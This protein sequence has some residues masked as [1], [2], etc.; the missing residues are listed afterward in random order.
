MPNKAMAYA[1][2]YRY[3][4]TATHRPLTPQWY[5]DVYVPGLGTLTYII[6][7]PILFTIQDEQKSL[8]KTISFHHPNIV[9]FD[10]EEQ[11][12]KLKPLL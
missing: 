12:E 4:Q 9:F 10:T 2:P 8:D 7:P 11:Y 3:G 6:T 1:S 5:R